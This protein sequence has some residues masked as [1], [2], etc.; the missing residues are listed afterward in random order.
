M[1]GL[2]FNVS[3][4][5]ESASYYRDFNSYLARCNQ[6]YTLLIMSKLQELSGFRKL[7]KNLEDVIIPFRVC[8]PHPI[9]CYFRD[10]LMAF[11]YN[12]LNKIVFINTKL[13]KMGLST[14]EKC[15]FCNVNKEDLF[16]LF[17]DCSHV[18]AFWFDFESW[19]S[20]LSGEKI[21]M[22]L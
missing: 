6:F 15:S 11:E 4:H 21:N 13:V 8:F 17:F 5:T 22:C 2:K 16:H 10:I 1:V 12:I 9:C 20:S 18:Q 19:W 14:T 7:A 3:P